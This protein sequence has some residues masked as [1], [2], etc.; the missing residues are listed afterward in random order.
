MRR[1]PDQ[2]PLELVLLDRTAVRPRGP[3]SDDVV[4]PIHARV[5]ESITLVGYDVSAERVRPGGTLTVT[6][7]WRAEG[8]LDGDYTAFV[9]LIDADG[10][11]VGQS[12]QQPLGGAYPTSLW[13]AGDVVRDAHRLG[14][15]ETS[16]P[17][18]CTLSTGLYNPSTDERLPAYRGE[19]GGRFKGDVIVA[20]GVT[21][22]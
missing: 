22:E 4:H 5:G 21:I 8:A 10:N 2:P 15:H 11:L 9:H 13:Q 20:G 14:I 16:A 18:A 17:G 6:L 19:D 1:S 7:V 12:D 3:V